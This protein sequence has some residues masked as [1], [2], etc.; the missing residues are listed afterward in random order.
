MLRNAGKKILIVFVFYFLFFKIMFKS[1]YILIIFIHIHPLPQVLADPLPLP[2]HEA[3]SYFSEIKQKP[4]TTTTPPKKIKTKTR[5]QNKS[6]PK[7]VGGQKNSQKSM[8]AHT[9]TKNK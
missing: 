1:K 9:Y 7:M 6:M 3:L 4:N 8:C 2:I 5:K